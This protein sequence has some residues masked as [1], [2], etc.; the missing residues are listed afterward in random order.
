MYRNTLIAVA[1]IVL[2]RADNSLAQTQFGHVVDRTPNPAVEQPGSQ[3]LLP[4][5]AVGTAWA[6]DFFFANAL[7]CPDY[8]PQGSA[9]D[10]RLQRYGRDG[11]VYSLNEQ[12]FRDSIQ[13]EVPICVV[14][15]GSF[16][17]AS[18]FRGFVDTY[19]WIRGAAPDLPL[20]IVFYRWPSSADMRAVIPQLQVERLGQ[21]ADCHGLRLAM[22]LRRL[23]SRNPVSILAHSHG[24][25]CASSALHLLAGGR[26]GHLQLS[27]TGA[28]ERLYRVVYGAAAIDHHWLNPNQR[29]GRAFHSVES[30]LNMRTRNDW[31]LD[32]YTFR[33]SY[34]AAALGDVGLTPS[35]RLI[36]GDAAQ[37]KYSEYDVTSIV[38]FGHTSRAYVSHMEI[39]RTFVPW[40]YYADRTATASKRLRVSGSLSRPLEERHQQVW[41]YGARRSKH[42][43][44]R[45]RAVPNPV[46]GLYPRRRPTTRS[47]RR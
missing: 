17:P 8:L 14:V 44:H 6:P 19:R 11:R 20:H 32:L 10:L 35:D 28:P 42:W 7:H 16:I 22:F 41:K 18:E 39:S 5:Y 45:S 29:F 37:H 3:I 24:T 26:V 21:R 13:P 34:S 15:H 36:L 33:S 31:A 43:N 9:L 25:R 2:A 40:L 4:R 27:G 38:G 47:A 46:L 12:Q 30:I 23:P 1:A